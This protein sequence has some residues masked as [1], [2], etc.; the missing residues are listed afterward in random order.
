MDLLRGD[1]AA[2]NAEIA[3]GRGLGRHR[4]RICLILQLMGVDVT[5]VEIVDQI[6]PVEDAEIAELARKQ[7]EKP[8]SRSKQAPR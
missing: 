5:V 3:A 6:M 4:H 2:R 8:G 7:L 1:G